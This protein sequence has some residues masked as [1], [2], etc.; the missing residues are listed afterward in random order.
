MRISGFDH[1]GLKAARGPRPPTMAARRGGP[2]SYRRLHIWRYAGFGQDVRRERAGNG[3]GSVVRSEA[4]ESTA[5]PLGVEVE[6][7]SPN[8]SR[9][10]LAR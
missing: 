9:Q 8:S 10:T 7:A 2:N 3:A 5:R 6:D 1:D 4:R